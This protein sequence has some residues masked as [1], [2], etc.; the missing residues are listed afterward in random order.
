[1]SETVR[2]FQAEAEANWIKQHQPEI[3]AKTHKFLLLSGYLTY[4]LTGLYRDSTGSQVAYIPFDYKK[5]RWA[6]KS[7]WKWQAVSIEEQMLPELVEPSHQMGVITAEASSA[8]G[9]PVCWPRG[10]ARGRS[11]RSVR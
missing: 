4:R 6:D 8:T 7:D 2:Y 10:L 9:I 3:W 11:G 1:M 5:L